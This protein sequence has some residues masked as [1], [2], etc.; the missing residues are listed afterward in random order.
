MRGVVAGR[1]I[2]VASVSPSSLTLLPAPRE[3][4]SVVWDVALP[5]TPQHRPYAIGLPL[6]NAPDHAE[7]GSRPLTT[8]AGEGD[9]FDEGP[10]GDD[11]DQGDGDEDDGRC[12]HQAGPVDDVQTEEI[13]EADLQRVLL[14]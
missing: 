12:G 6:A 4:G 10:L 8:Q 7:E 14:R 1:D 5:G 13:E 9:A 3:E 2:V 11:E